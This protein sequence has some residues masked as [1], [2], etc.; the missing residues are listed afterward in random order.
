MT[1]SCHSGSACVI[2]EFLS[3]VASP[4]IKMHAFLPSSSQEGK[5]DS[6]AT[7]SVLKMESGMWL[8]GDVDGRRCK[9]CLSFVTGAIRVTPNMPS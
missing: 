8:S 9:V 4:Y 6:A 1:W 2:D 3:V 7:N 5:G